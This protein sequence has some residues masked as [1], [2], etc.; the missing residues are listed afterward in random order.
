MSNN[1]LVEDLWASGKNIDLPVGVVVADDGNRG[2][3][4]VATA[5]ES[6]LENGLHILKSYTKIKMI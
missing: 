3:S 5:S 2:A 4:K 1:L 6:Y